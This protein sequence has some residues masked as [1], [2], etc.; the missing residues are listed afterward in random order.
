ML[1]LATAAFSSS[2]VMARRSSLDRGC[3]LRDSDSTFIAGT[4]LYR[5]CAV[6]V[7][8]TNVTRGTGPLSRPSGP[9]RDGCHSAELRFVVD[10]TGVPEQR[11]AR[12]LRTNDSSYADA[13]VATLPSWRYHPARIKNRP[14]RQIVTE[15]EAMSITVAHAVAGAGSPASSSGVPD[16]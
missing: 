12:I 11:T 4:P 2:C 7:K 8:A 16:C 6:D 5:E 15:R 1:M 10:T 3:G 9:L 14:V 13:V